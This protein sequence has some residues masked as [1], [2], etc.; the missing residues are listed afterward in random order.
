MTHFPVFSDARPSR[1]AQAGSDHAS[2][3]DTPL[4]QVNS[5]ATIAASS[6]TCVEI[7]VATPRDSREER[8]TSN[9][10]VE[11]DSKKETQAHTLVQMNRREPDLVRTEVDLSYRKG[12]Q[13]KVREKFDDI[14]DVRHNSQLCSSFE[15]SN[16]DKFSDEINTVGRLCTEKS[17]KFFEAIGASSYVLD[18][19]KNGHHPVLIDEVSSYEIP[20]NGSFIS[21]LILHCQRF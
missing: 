3:F 19:M 9:R 14:F 7:S 15:H 18:I 12:V 2:G 1:A 6:G 5:D 16:F 21:T 10:T 11:S 17:V 8:V 4:P 13:E 20:N